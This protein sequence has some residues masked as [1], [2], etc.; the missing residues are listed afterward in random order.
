MAINGQ[1]GNPTNLS[2]QDG[3][4]VLSFEEL[5]HGGVNDYLPNRKGY[6]FIGGEDITSS[7]S[8][9]SIQT[10]L[11]QSD[12]LEI[13]LIGLTPS[14]DNDDL[15]IQLYENGVLET[16]G[17]Y[18]IAKQYWNSA[19]ASAFS[20]STSDTS[21]SLGNV[22]NATYEQWNGFLTLT[23][24]RNSSAQTKYMVQGGA[25]QSSGVWYTYARWGELPQASNVDGI[26]IFFGTGNITAGKVRIYGYE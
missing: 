5:G 18:D 24:A 7:V 1:V 19:T 3:S 20:H 22:G 10:G 14:V 2:D 9:L 21:I 23:D 12:F 8:S 6:F 25:I 16:T 4:S 15:Q 26:K 13:Q 17:V 11:N